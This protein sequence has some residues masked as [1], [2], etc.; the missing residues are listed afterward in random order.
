MA[1]ADNLNAL[2]RSGR[3]PEFHPGFMRERSF[4]RPPS[5]Y[6]MRDGA[7]K[8]RSVHGHGPAHHYNHQQR[9]KP[10]LEIYRPP[11]VRVDGPNK[12]NVHAKEFTMAMG[13]QHNLQTSRSSVNV[14]FNQH[15][16]QHGLQHSKSANIM[17]LRHQTN[18]N[19]HGMKNNNRQ[20]SPQIPAIPLM[21]SA[22]AHIIQNTPKVHFKLEQTPI[23]N[24]VEN[25]VTIPGGLQRSKSMSAADSLARSLSLGLDIS[26]DVPNLGPFPAEIEEIITLACEDPNQLS[27][28]ALINLSNS[29]MQRAVESQKYALPAARLCIKII[30]SEKKETFLETLINTCRQWY[31]I[32]RLS[33]KTKSRTRFTAF[34]A[35][36]ME[37]FS[38]LKRRQLQLK[39]QCDGISPP[40]VLL[41]LLCKSCEEC[42]KP[43]ISS[44]SEIECLFF[45]L[46]C[47]GRDLEI[48]MPNQLD[49]LLRQVRDAFL[50][51]S[52]EPSIR[53]TLLQLIELQASHWQLPGS[54][55]LYYYP[56]T[57]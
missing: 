12:L 8:R 39:T 5:Q 51:T 32:L 52:M 9:G 6:Q 28:R 31:Q 48:H 34:M 30:A 16:M 24:G 42:V 54:T 7:A 55:V 26:S 50:S 41:T 1:Q 27:A 23:A 25:K 15:Q 10:S 43:P 13:Q 17:G 35:F 47:I 22:S 29:L 20:M 57:K 37:M 21:T 3:L 11:N 44:L 36:L 2:R 4:I 46:T 56:S 45:V 19:H 14:P 38:Q 40:M 53:K 33:V 18:N 49:K